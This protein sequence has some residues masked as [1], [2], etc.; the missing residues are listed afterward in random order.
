KH[1]IGEHIG[2]RAVAENVIGRRALAV[3]EAAAAEEGE[4]GVDLSGEQQEHEDRAEAASA[5][6]P[7]LEVHIL[8]AAG[9]KAKRERQQRGGGNEG[10][11]AVHGSP[12]RLAGSAA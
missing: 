9:E 10:Q 7:L 2:E 1:E 8:A 6:R 3:S 12:S 5:H 11:R 4:G